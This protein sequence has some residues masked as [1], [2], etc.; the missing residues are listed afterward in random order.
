MKIKVILFYHLKQKAGTGFLEMEVP[1][2]STI[3]DLKQ[4][5]EKAYPQLRSHL[6]NVLVL[7][8]QMIVL[9]D[10]LIKNSSEISFLTP[11]GGG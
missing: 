3:H 9:D 2:K 4:E 6:A 8:N 11:V 10:D 5:L 1:E 7:M